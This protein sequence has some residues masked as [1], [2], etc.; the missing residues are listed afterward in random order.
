M[1]IIIVIVVLTA[2]IIFILFSFFC[3]NSYLNDAKVSY[4]S[5]D[6]QVEGSIYPLNPERSILS[7]TQMVDWTEDKALY[8]TTCK[9]V[10]SGKNIRD[11]PIESMA[12][13]K[14]WLRT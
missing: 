1:I 13:G 6:V 8:V 5:G 3:G 7:V 4:S 14:M 10:Y 12:D 2:L 11:N 9:A